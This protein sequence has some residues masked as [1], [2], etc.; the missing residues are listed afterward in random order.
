MSAAAECIRREQVESELASVCE[1]AP[2]WFAQCSADGTIAAV[3]PALERALDNSPEPVGCFADLLDPDRR[4]EGRQFLAELFEGKRSSFQVVS[5]NPLSVLEHIQWT[6]WRV[7]GR[8]KTDYVLALGQEFRD[9]WEAERRLRQAQRLEAVGRLAGSVAHDF[10]NLLTGLLLCC[11][12]LI[13]GLEKDHR[14][15]KYADEI[16]G[17][18]L[19]ASGL[20]RQLISI[21]RPTTCEPALLSLN[22]VAEQL[23]PLLTRMAGESVT[24]EFRLNPDLGLVKMD[25]TQAQQVL[26]NLVLNARD[27]MPDGGCIAIATRNCRIQVLPQATARADASLLP[28]AVL[29]VADEGTGMDAT[30]QA[31][32]FEAFY[33]T[34]GNQGTGLG[35][36]AVHDIVTGS[37]GLIHIDSAPGR[38]TRVTILLPLVPE[39]APGFEQPAKVLPQI[40]NSYSKNK[41][42]V[43]P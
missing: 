8:S 10:N 39:P 33:T 30:T 38:G 21:T 6:V 22:E 25:R 43:T 12:L 31:H 26:L 4:A 19:Q 5:R 29:E 40:S 14:A 36:V 1:N 42:E 16:R 9:N 37:G 35:L 7:P 3:N 17:A 23:R 24:L 27:A 18:T 20:V 34:K 2:V 13:G 11:D 15:R 41:K 28:C 32:L